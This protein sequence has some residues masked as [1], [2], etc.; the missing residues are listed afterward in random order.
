[1]TVVYIDVL[2]V[3]NFIIDYL[4]LL[5]SAKLTGQFLCRWRLALGGAF[6]GCYAA[7][8]FL[9][10]LEFLSHPVC[11]VSAGVLMAL[12]AFGGSRRLPRLMA[13]LFGVSAAFGGGVY[14]LELLGGQGVTLERGVAVSTLDLGAILLSAAACYG[15]LS[16]VFRRTAGHSTRELQA[17]VVSMEGRQILLTALTDTGNTLTDPA[18]GRPVMVVEGKRMTGLLG[19]KMDETDLS[20]PVETMARLN[21]RRYRLLPYQAVGVECGMLLAVRVDRVTVGKRD[22]GSILVALSPTAVSDG[23]GYHA[24]IGAI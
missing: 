24:L 22:L 2:F 4:L 13:A 19:R 10:G 15:V 21:D 17:A 16:V 18:T 20:R 23:G 12:I 6:G 14:A 7:A 5:T 9:P 8:V 3:L 1:M 11:R